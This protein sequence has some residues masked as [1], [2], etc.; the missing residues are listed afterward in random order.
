M[1]THVRWARTAGITGF[2]VSWKRSPVLDR[3]LDLLVRVAQ[4]ENF[5]LAII[6][7]GLDF[8]RRPLPVARIGEDLRRFAQRYDREPVFDLFGKPL[9]IWSG[10]WEFS[11]EA[12]GSVT[13]TV[14][15]GLLVLASE[16]KVRGYDSIA[17]LV[18]GNAYYWSSVNPDTNENHTPKLKEMAERVRLRRGCGS[19]RPHPASTHA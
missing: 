8:F 5:K 9:V 10:T 18:D 16:R 14:R 19:L 3:R 2:V 7:Q 6:Y 1:R 11:P 13:R 4:A 15:P 17:T 12:I